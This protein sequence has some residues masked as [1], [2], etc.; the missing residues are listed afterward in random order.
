[1]T[2]EVK[3]IGTT[4]GVGVVLSGQLR[5]LD[6]QASNAQ[7]ACNAAD[8]VLDEVAAKLRVLLS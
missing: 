2:I 8:D 1:M 7:A 3:L 6:W 5:S 4:K